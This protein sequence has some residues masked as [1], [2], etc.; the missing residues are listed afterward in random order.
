MNARQAIISSFRPLPFFARKIWEGVLRAISR[1]LPD[2]GLGPFLFLT[3]QFFSQF[4]NRGPNEILARTV[5]AAQR[6]FLAPITAPYRGP[7]PFRHFSA[8]G[9]RALTSHGLVIH[10]GV[11][12]IATDG[13]ACWRNPIQDGRPSRAS[14]SAAGRCRNRPRGRLKF[15]KTLIFIKTVIRP[16]LILDQ[17]FRR[18]IALSNV[19]RD[20]QGGTDA[21]FRWASSIGALDT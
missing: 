8:L 1:L 4:G 5:R 3:P 21:R 12:T 9:S 19:R 15:L 20:R 17:V 2:Q 11:C 16:S 13:L 7:T 6:N 14:I 18:D 10:R